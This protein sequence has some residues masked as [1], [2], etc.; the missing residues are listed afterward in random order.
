MFIPG[1][2]VCDIE[3]NIYSHNT[4]PHNTSIHSSVLGTLTRIN[5]LV[6][7]EPC[8]TYRYIPLAGD[9]IVGRVS[10]LS[11]K[12]WKIEANAQLECILSLTTIALPDNV[13]RRKLEQDEM[14]MHSFFD[15]GDVL[16]AEIQ[17]VN[18]GSA[19][20]STRNEKYGKLT[21]GVLRVVPLRIVGSYKSSFVEN[22]HL[23]FVIGANGYI[24]IQL[25]HNEAV[26]Y[27]KMVAALHYFD[28]CTA[29][30]YLIDDKVL[31][32]L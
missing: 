26:N 24:F 27:A 8:T 3:D 17:K 16:V 32:S 9:I 4:Y 15:V 14:L 28:K 29:H 18:L 22:E 20:L 21:N 1:E 7:V 11:V 30:G 31:E 5:K 6:M 19:V 25:R 13:Q 10:M 12:R 23:K 2:K